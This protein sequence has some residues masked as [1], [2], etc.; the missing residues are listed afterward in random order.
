MLVSHP[1]SIDVT[2]ETVWRI[3]RLA[4]CFTSRLMLLNSIRQVAGSNLAL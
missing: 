2:I 3:L 4:I 1:A